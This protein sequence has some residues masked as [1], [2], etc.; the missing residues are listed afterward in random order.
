[1]SMKRLREE[2]AWLSGMLTVLEERLKETEAR[3]ERELASE[4]NH[5]ESLMVGRFLQFNLI[6][7]R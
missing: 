7:Y 1:M 5:M 2:N 3:H 6:D 4:H